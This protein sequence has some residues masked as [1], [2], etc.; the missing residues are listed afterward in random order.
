MPGEETERI[1]ILLQA[2]DKDFQRAM[3]R[4]NKLIAKFEREANKAVSGH[5]KTVERNLATVGRSVQV[6]AGTILGSVLV[7]SV[8]M[9]FSRTAQAVK[10]VAAIGD[11]ARRSGLGV[12]QF[13]E[14]SFVAEQSRIP[15]DALIDGMKELSLR[16]DEFATTGNGSGAEAFQRLGFGASDLAERLKDPSALMEEIIRRMEGL[17]RAAQIRIADEVF[18]GTGGERFVELIAQGA[19]GISAIR[20]RA[21]DLGVVMDEGAIQKAAELDRKFEEV[22][23]RV[24]TLAKTITVELAAAI[25]DAVSLDVDEI[26]GS[27]ERA[28]KMLGEANYRALKGLPTVTDDTKSDLSEVSALYGLVT[29]RAR[30]LSEGLADLSDEL[31]DDGAADSADRFARIADGLSSLLYHF[32][33]GQIEAS[34]FNQNINDL[35]VEAKGVFD[36]LSDIDKVDFST[37]GAG[38]DGLIQALRTAAGVAKEVTNNL[39]VDTRGDWMTLAPEGAVDYSLPPGLY[40]PQTS[41]RPKAAPPLVDERSAS[42]GGKSSNLKGYL[43][44]VE[45]TRQEI[46]RLEAEAVSMTVAAGYSTELGDALEYARKRAELLYAAQRDGKAITPEL[47]AQIDALAQAYV[48]AGMNADQAR[49]KV[50]ELRDASKRGA[51][52]LSGIFL[53]MLDG[54]ASAQDA[55][56]A[57]IS[58]IARAQVMAGFK[59]L[60]GS[61]GLLGGIANLLFPSADGN[62]FTGG[63]P[64]AFAKG[65]V[66]DSP[67]LFPMRGAQTG[68]MGESGAEAIMPLARD[69]AGRLGVRAQSGRASPVTGQVRVVLEG[70][71]EGVT[72]R[73]AADIAGAIS[74]QVSTSA[75]Q[76]QRA[77][78][79]SDVREDSWRKG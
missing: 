18:G 67:T 40:A 4:N 8:E 41:P 43:K 30:D 52:A 57:L 20:Q 12:E 27:A 48:E 47:T 45:D 1:A 29:S 22:K 16:G 14:L 46:A 24:S 58:E 3:D 39:P 21:R 19:D 42:A 60:S 51:D 69:T 71:P 23:K 32:E 25:D 75:M 55:V 36:D 17:D 38:I 72:A 34:D 61:G 50:E 44:E 5:A 68:L 53:S 78:L 33:H 15:V 26:F 74:V 62:V 2:R 76:R 73:Q 59:G 28:V 7:K 63:A 79:A 77:S 65:G 37:I 13:Q 49:D 9:V 35:S 70:L 31:R 66:V 6:M 64:V 54:S 11:E 56:K 10:G